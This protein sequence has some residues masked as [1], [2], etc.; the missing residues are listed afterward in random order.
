MRLDIDARLRRLQRRI[1]ALSVSA[2]L[3]TILLAMLVVQVAR[4]GWAMVTPIGRFGDWRVAPAISRDTAASVLTGFDPFFRLNRQPASAT[5][6]VTSL[7]LTLFGTR[8]DDASG[9]GSAIIA[10]PD[11]VQNSYSVG[12]EIVAGVRLKEVAFDHVT[13]DR[14]GAAEDLFIVQPSGSAD[15]APVATSQNSVPAS[16]VTDAPNG[17]GVS[18][19]DLRAAIGF[20]PRIDGGRVTG[21]AVRPQG[22]SGLFQKLGFRG[23]DVITQVNGHPVS[24]G[25]EVQNAAAGLAKGGNLS[26]SVERGAEILPL[27]ISVKGQ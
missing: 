27:V 5:G 17:A 12:D 24:G 2:T 6:V 1:P 20:I 3:G 11:G 26:V 23:G 25:D 8:L 13:I 18:T 10:T 16:L 7:Q 22:E 14:G 9:R 19:S 4:L 21:L 15:A